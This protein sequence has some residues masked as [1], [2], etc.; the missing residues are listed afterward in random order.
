M[1]RLVYTPEAKKQID[2]FNHSLKSQIKEA[3]ELIANDPLIGK[4]LTQ[5][6]SDFMSYRTGDYRIIYKVHHKEI[7][8]IIVAVG[9]RKDIY[10]KV[11]RKL[12]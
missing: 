1:Y 6:L 7:L 5:E 2:R 9:H 10:K 12:E 4:R 3:A 11:T 8:V